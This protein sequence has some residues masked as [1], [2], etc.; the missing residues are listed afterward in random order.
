MTLPSILLG[1]V[2]ST[3]LG[4][5]FHFWKG[6]NLWHLILYLVLSGIGFWIGQFI[7]GQLGFTLGSIGTLNLLMAFIGA[8]FT[9]IIGNW[10]FRIERSE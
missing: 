4:A 1:F 6:G 10:L 8:L 9:L 5:A 3:L 7:A 2:I